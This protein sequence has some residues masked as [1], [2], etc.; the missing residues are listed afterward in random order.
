MNRQQ[1]FPA[2]DLSLAFV[3]LDAEGLHLCLE[4]PKDLPSFSQVPQFLLWQFL[5][6]GVKA[7]L[8]E[9]VLVWGWHSIE[10]C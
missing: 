9:L 3:D 1:F 4:I 7:G 5:V 6:V 10:V 8:Q 2:L